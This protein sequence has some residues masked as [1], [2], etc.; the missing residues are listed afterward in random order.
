[1]DAS[2]SIGK[3]LLICNIV[4]CTSCQVYRSKFDCAPACG[5][6]CASVSQIEGRIVETT[7][8]PDI[9]LRNPTQ[10]PVLGE[11]SSPELFE[12]FRASPSTRRIW[13]APTIDSSG[14]LIDGH[15]VYFGERKHP[16]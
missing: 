1:M 8:G 4:L 3:A 6:P 15:Y 2:P 5:V 11:Y 9:F 16:C 7:E 13:M 12:E 14:V 10:R